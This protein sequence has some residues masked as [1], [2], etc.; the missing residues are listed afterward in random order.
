MRWDNTCE[1]HIRCNQTSVPI[2]AVA[3]SNASSPNFE[4]TSFILPLSTIANAPGTLEIQ[5]YIQKIEIFHKTSTIF[6]HVPV[7]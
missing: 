3:T 2:L 7:S 6:L 5:H 4:W 1:N